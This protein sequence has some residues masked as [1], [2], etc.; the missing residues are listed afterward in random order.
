MLAN[1][2]VSSESVPAKSDKSTTPAPAADWM[3]MFDTPGTGL[4]ASVKSAPTR[5]ALDQILTQVIES[6]F[7]APGDTGTR[8]NY[9]SIAREATQGPSGNLEKSREATV[10]LLQHLRQDKQLMVIAR[11]RNQGL[12]S[13]HKR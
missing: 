13:F 9:L 7:R 12:M 2:D 11:K 5:D 6:L 10:I 4:L 8:A 3:A 1:P